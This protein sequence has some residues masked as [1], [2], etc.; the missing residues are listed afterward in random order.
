VIDPIQQRKAEHLA[1]AASGEAE[2]RLA[3]G[4]SDI[5]LRPASLPETALERIDCS[6][7]LLGRRLRFPVVIAGMTGGFDRAAEVNAVLA[8][9]AES[10][11][12]AM[13]VGSQRA[14][15]ANT[16]LSQSYEVARRL[17]PSAFLIA[18]I[19]APQLIRQ[20]EADALSV[21]A[22]RRAV[23]M[24]GADALAVHLNYLQ[25]L[26]QPEG[27]HRA[28]GC[29]E[30]IARVSS[31]LPL[32][33]IA[34][35]TGGGMTRRTAAILRACGTAALD[36]GGRGGTSFAAVE[37]MRAAGQGDARHALLGER[38]R[39]WGIPTPVAV[40][41]AAQEGLPVIATGGIR[42]GLEAAK[43]IAL[44]AT[45]VGIGRPLAQ[46]AL[47]GSGA[48]ER[49]LERFLGELRLAM[50]LSG[51]ATV[52]DLRRQPPIVLGRTR[53]WIHELTETTKASGRI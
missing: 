51:S 31:E 2:A 44:G 28:R 37:G 30:A 34:K 19:G 18:N 26:I 48:V 53:E 14:A 49:W 41:E 6:Q 24:I 5:V 7:V 52:A 17:A 9:A 40:L 27:D 29:A 11:G 32:P 3:A 12:I 13:G 33:L 38:F 39:D 42:T 23:E 20:G 36:V 21:A 43:A 1:V 45:A 46:A 4:W 10:F 8:Q 25:E 50:F 35:E 47:Q 22:A 15:L 16:A